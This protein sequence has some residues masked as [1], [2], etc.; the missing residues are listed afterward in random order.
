MLKSVSGFGIYVAD[1]KKSAAFYKKLGFR[2]VEKDNVTKAYINW[3]WIQLIENKTAEALGPK[4]K[5]EALSKQKGAGLYVNCAVEK[6][7]AYYMSLVK[8]GLKPSSKPRDWPWGNREFV[9]RD[10]DGY[11]I[12]FFQKLK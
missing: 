10:P 1:T 5:K 3:F 6:I 9:V 11:K 8:K 2:I 12:V 4:F 7:D